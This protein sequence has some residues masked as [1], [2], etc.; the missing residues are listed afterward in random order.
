MFLIKFFLGD[1]ISSL[2]FIIDFIDFLFK[3]FNLKFADKSINLGKAKNEDRSL[4]QE[5]IELKTEEE[6]NVKE[7]LINLLNI[8][9]NAKK[10]TQNQYWQKHLMR[11]LMKKYKRKSKIK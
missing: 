8:E 6:K 4:N 2:S 9:D 5:I 3:G 11:I 10:V 7:Y 1:V